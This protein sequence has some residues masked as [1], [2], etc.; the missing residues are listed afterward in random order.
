MPNVIRDQF[1][2][3]GT[4]RRVPT[5]LR[6]VGRSG[7]ALIGCATSS[8]R[9]VPEFLIIGAKR[10]GTTSLFRY[11]EGHPN[12]APLFPSARSPLMRGNQKGVH[13]F[14][15]NWH[16][17]ERW[18]RGHFQTQQTRSRHS[19]ITGEA[20]PYYL[21]HPLAAGRA[22]QIV[23]DA[24]I[25]VLVREPVARTYS[26]WSEQRRNGIERLSFADA[27]EVEAA[28][29]GDDDRRLRAGDI[30]RSFSHEFQ[31]YTRQS[32]YG[33]SLIRWSTTFPQEQLL[34]VRSEDL[35]ERPVDVLHRVTAFL[36]LEQHAPSVT[37]PWNAS[38]ASNTDPIDE[39]LR[40]R[41]RKRFEADRNVLAERFGVA[42]E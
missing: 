5:P 7:F 1:P 31:S 22:K 32:E 24:K 36:G 12:I 38:N 4:N 21:F 34:V 16:R 2:G 15:S 41:L 3:V 35:Y 25:V 30:E 40:A 14:D 20:S 13:F 27:I 39:A 9:P 33:N 29:I 42:W 37:D 18:Y 10:A 11:L 8:V 23:P 28:R 26:A 19:Q 17:G 6:S